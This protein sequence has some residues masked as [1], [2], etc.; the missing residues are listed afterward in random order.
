MR[1]IPLLEETTNGKDAKE[2]KSSTRQQYPPNSPRGGKE[3]G[4]FFHYDYLSFLQ[5]QRDKLSYL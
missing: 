2:G 5:L 1:R 4:T 3:R